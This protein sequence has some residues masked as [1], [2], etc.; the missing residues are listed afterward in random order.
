MGVAFLVMWPVLYTDV[1]EAW[2]VTERRRRLFIGG[3]GILA[4]LAIA[5][6]ATL[7]WSFLPEGALRQA[8]FVLA[9]LTWVSSLVL[10]LCRRSCASTAISC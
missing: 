8:A 9:A 6:W 2:A 10:N 4:E 3:A 7:A 5:A 1:N